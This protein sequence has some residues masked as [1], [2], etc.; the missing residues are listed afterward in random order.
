M[1]YKAAPDKQA[2]LLLGKRCQSG[3]TKGRANYCDNAK[4]ASEGKYRWSK[5]DQSNGILKK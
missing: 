1:P 3:T 4:L 5:L 2:R